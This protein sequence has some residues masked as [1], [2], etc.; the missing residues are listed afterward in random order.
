VPRH[1]F[2]PTAALIA[3]AVATMLFVAGCGSSDGGGSGSG[4][5]TATTAGGGDGYGGGGA[6]TTSGGAASGSGETTLTAQ[7]LKWSTDTLSLPKGSTTLKVV[8][9]DTAEH[10]FTADSI[11]VDQDIEGGEDADITLDLSNA[12]GSVEFHCKYHPTTMKGTI[13]VTG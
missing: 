10:S 2:I 4:G 7:G 6:T 9:A 3:L 12:S 11:N 5:G 1:R 13:T 8:N